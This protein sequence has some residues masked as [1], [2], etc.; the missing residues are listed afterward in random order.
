MSVPSEWFADAEF[1]TS[2]RPA[3]FDESRLARTSREAQAIVRL[4][5]VAPGDT[6]VDAC[7]G[8]GRYALEFARAGLKVTAFDLCEPLVMELDSAAA[9]CGLPVETHCA[10]VRAFAVPRQYDA[11][12]LLF[13]AIGYFDD[14]QVDVAT[15]RNIVRLLRPGGRFLIDSFSVHHIARNL[16][17]MQEE[18]DFLSAKVRRFIPERGDAHSMWIE[19]TWL[20]ARGNDARRFEYSQRIYTRSGLRNLLQQ[21]GFVDC[22]IMGDYEGLPYGPACESVVALARKPAS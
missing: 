12:V 7:C 8:Y 14:P 5:G 3:M 19:G 11:V 13:A 18:E 20:I 21:A 17:E 16:V 15:L 4:L 10:D 22:E 1:W 9:R 2:V 6:I